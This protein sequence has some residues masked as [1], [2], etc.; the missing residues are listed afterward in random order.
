MEIIKINDRVK[1]NT[2]N[3]PTVDVNAG[4]ELKEQI[5]FMISNASFKLG[6]LKNIQA[7]ATRLNVMHT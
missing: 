2:P 3:P 7:K 6:A 1:L 4:E 5:P